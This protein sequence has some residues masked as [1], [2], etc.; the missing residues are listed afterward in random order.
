V[1][2]NS[3]RPYKERHSKALAGIHGRAQKENEFDFVHVGN[4]QQCEEQTVVLR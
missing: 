3:F 2:R 1:H 4:P